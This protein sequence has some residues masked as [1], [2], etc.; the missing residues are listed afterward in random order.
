MS[1][2]YYKENIKNDPIKPLSSKTKNWYKKAQVNEDYYD[3]EIAF[4]KNTS[5][6][7]LKKI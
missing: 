7:I 5:P 4:D 1:K 2:N 6:E 3:I